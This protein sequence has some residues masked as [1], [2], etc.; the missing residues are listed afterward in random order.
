[1]STPF[2]SPPGSAIKAASGAGCR[3]APPDRPSGLPRL[4]H[5]QQEVLCGACMRANLEIGSTETSE[6][7][8]FGPAPSNVRPAVPLPVST[9]AQRF[10]SAGEHRL[11]P[12]TIDAKPLFDSHVSACD[13]LVAD[14]SF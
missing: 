14:L 13:F 3:E 11:L 7:H 12:L 5:W 9:T 2:S 4:S 8:I 10:L 1:F 6:P